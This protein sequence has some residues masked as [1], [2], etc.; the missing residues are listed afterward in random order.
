MI[1]FY[2]HLLNYFSS[3]Q[4]I[5]GIDRLPQHKPIGLL[6]VEH[7]FATLPDQYDGMCLTILV[8]CKDP[9]E[10]MHTKTGFSWRQLDANLESQ[11]VSKMSSKYKTISLNVV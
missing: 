6:T 3:Y 5:F 8:G 7:S 9:L 4:H 2:L 1:L 10:S 11:L